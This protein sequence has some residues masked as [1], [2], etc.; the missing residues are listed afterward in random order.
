VQKGKVGGAFST[1]NGHKICTLNLVEEPDGKILLGVDWNPVLKQTLKNCKA[2]LWSSIDQ[3][4]SG[5][6]VVPVMNIRF[7]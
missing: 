5:P 7:I 4:G 3:V 2:K 1:H 6:D